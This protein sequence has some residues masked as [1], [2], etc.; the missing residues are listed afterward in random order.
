MADAVPIFCPSC[1]KVSVPSA[2]AG[3][4]VICGEC[5]ASLVLFDEDGKQVARKATIRD[6]ALLTND[7]L[8]VLRQARGKL[9][10]R[11]KGGT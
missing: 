3:V 10:P 5:G 11:A 9:A 7:E 4:L 1:T 6:V 8:A 2:A